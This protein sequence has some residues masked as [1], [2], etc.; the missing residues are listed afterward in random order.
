MKRIIL[1]ASVFAVG[2]SAFGQEPF[3]NASFETWENVGN[4]SEEPTDYSSLKTA[5]PGTLAAF[6]PQVLWQAGSAHTGS[7]CVH[8]KVAAYNSLAG[9]SPNGI[10][11][12][13]RA[14]AST[15]A[16]DAYV[17]TDPNDAKWN[18]PVT[19]RPDSL[20]GWY[21]YSPVG[22]DKGK[23]HILLHDDTQEG[24]LPKQGGVDSHWVG[25]AKN[26]FFTAQANWTRFSI[27]VNYFNNNYPDY[28]LMV[29]AAGD[30][31]LSITDSELWLDDIE[32][33]YNPLDVTIAPAASQNININTDGTT[34]TATESTSADAV[35]V[36]REWLYATTSGGPYSSFTV[37][38]TGTTYTPNFASAGIYYVVCT[39]DF[40]AQTAT[41]NEVEIVVVDPGV[42]SVTVSPSA[43]QTLLGNTDGNTLTA[44]ESPSAASSRE[45]MW[46][47]TSGSGYASF[48]VAETTTSYTPNFANLG[49]YYI[50]CESDFSGDMQ[51]SNEVTI[52]VN[53]YAGIESEDITLKV[54]KSDNFIR[55]V[56]EGIATGSTAEFFSLDGKRIQSEVIN[57]SVMNIALNA[58]TGV[59]V[60]R[61]IDGDKIITG[62][63]QY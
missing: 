60:Y 15:T 2:L 48:T 4:P 33:I 50:I 62:K 52:I 3:E 57:A 53:G 45:W 38:E 58:P 41:S 43:S 19:H 6:A 11:T 35:N 29:A 26:E 59:Y 51:T 13:G 23:V 32:L 25:E 61:I 8:L 27:P 9:V 5:T 44:T 49:T 46:S 10:I 63:V 31:T 39:T 36:T 42:N 54:F 1:F 40:G 21:K 34:L 17:F 30:S 14:L 28:I 7:Y 16:S 56:Q 47:N 12:N 37:A 24:A 22:G 18:T 55:I 20:V